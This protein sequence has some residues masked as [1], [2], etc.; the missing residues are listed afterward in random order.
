LE[1]TLR[2]A[3][4]CFDMRRT[5]THVPTHQSPIRCHLCPELRHVPA[6]A[7]VAQ[8]LSELLATAA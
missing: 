8:L 1:T 4:R 7:G 3:T 5:V 6:L 2:T